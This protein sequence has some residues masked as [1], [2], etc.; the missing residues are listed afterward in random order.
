MA[1]RN[2]DKNKIIRPSGIARRPQTFIVIFMD[3]LGNARKHGETQYSCGIR[4]EI[5]YYEIE[6]RILKNGRS[7]GKIVR[8][9]FRDS[10]FATKRPGTEGRVGHQLKET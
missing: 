8:L 9:Y 1:T 2:L 10:L 4:R 3:A 6:Y 5:P 7:T